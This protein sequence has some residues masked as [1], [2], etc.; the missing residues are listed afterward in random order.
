MKHLVI[1]LFLCLP[2]PAARAAERAHRK[3]DMNIKKDAPA[4]AQTFCIFGGQSGKPFGDQAAF[5]S[6]IWKSDI[7]YAGGSPGRP[8]DQ[9]ARLEILKAMREARGSKIAVGFEELAVPLQPILDEYTAGKISE[10]DFLQKTGRR[11]G[12][13]PD[14][15]PYRP[16]F[17]FIIQNK[18]RAL[19]LDP[20]DDLV[21]GIGREGPAALNETEKKLLPAQLKTGNRKKYLEFLKTSFDGPAASS[22]TAAGARDWE[23]HLAAVSAWNESAGAA[24]ADFIN[25]KPGW[26]MLVL[27]GNDRLIYNAALPA[28]VKSRAAK[29][30]QASFYA[31][32]AEKCPAALPRERRDLANYIWYTDSAAAR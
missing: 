30:R 24:I 15:A 1:S 27:A 4:P 16:I 13:Q 25:S 28:S 8:A 21:V 5:K 26:S 2:G 23:N 6:V 9:Q 19:A 22:A 14:F 10:E 32:D 31:E 29:V 17:N 20:P 11:K 7:V 18:L 3:P 12:P